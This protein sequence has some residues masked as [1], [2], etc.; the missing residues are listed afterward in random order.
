MAA[1]SGLPVRANV[2][3]VAHIRRE[4]S[5]ATGPRSVAFTLSIV[6]KTN[7]TSSAWYALSLPSN[8]GVSQLNEYSQTGARFCATLR[9]A[10]SSVRMRKFES[11]RVEMRRSDGEALGYR[12]R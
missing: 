11:V 4:R 8:T 1:L 12:P 9:S 5:W 10:S 6:L 7:G 3:Q 2:A